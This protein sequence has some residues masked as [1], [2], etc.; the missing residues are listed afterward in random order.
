MK[1]EKGRRKEESEERIRGGRK[2]RKEVRGPPINSFQPAV[3]KSGGGGPKK[4]KDSQRPTAETSVR[5]GQIRSLQRGGKGE[6]RDGA[7]LQVSGGY[8]KQKEENEERDQITK[9]I[10]CHTVSN[11]SHCG[12]DLQS[13]KTAERK[14]MAILKKGHGP[15]G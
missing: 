14:A 10:C 9:D 12:A 11:G 3:K 15:R 5:N 6:R 4:R 8:L 2:R 1:A 13:D 7:A